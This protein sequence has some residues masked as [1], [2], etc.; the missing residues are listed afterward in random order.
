MIFPA[1]HPES[2]QGFLRP[3]RV[4]IQEQKTPLIINRPSECGVLKEENNEGIA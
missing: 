1:S 2:L 4:T 3:D